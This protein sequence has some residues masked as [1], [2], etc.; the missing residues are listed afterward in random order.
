MEQNDSGREDA[1]KAK[2][3]LD[4]Q[5]ASGEID[6]VEYNQKVIMLMTPDKHDETETLS[7]SSKKL[8]K[9]PYFHVGLS[10]LISTIA[11]VLPSWFKLINS[12]E[13][14]FCV[15]NHWPEG[16]GY[17]FSIAIENIGLM[18]ITP[19]LI[20]LPLILAYIAKT[21]IKNTKYKW[22]SIL[23]DIA[24][25]LMAIVAVVHVFGAF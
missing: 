2:A 4:A 5:L 23:L 22:L 16:T 21:K 18:L 10:L 14:K 11:L 7:L 12:K 20:V 6:G 19:F 17:C 15:D 13:Y 24:A 3:E 8:R 9:S 25:F 1:K